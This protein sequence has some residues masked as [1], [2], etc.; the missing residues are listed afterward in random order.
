MRKGA[1]WYINFDWGVTIHGSDRRK[2]LNFSKAGM[3]NEE[4]CNDME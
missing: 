2:N 4:K 3:K 1:I